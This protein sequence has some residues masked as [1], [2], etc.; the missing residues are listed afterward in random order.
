MDTA[1]ITPLNFTTYQS[2]DTYVN[3]HYVLNNVILQP[4]D[5]TTDSDAIVTKK[6]ALFLI[7]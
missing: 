3:S 6:A 1:A 7:Y 4:S 5:V 2:C